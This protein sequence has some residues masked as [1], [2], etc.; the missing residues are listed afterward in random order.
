VPPLLSWRVKDERRTDLWALAGLAHLS[1]GEDAGPQHIFPVFYRDE[2]GETFISPVWATWR[3]GGEHWR[4]VPPLLTAYSKDKLFSP[5]VG[6]DKG[7]RGGFVYPVTPLAGFRH[8]DYSGSWLFPLFSHRRH[9]TS[10]NIQ[11]SFLWGNY[12]KDSRTSRSGIFPVYGYRNHGAFELADTD[13]TLYGTYGKE[14][15][16]LPLIWYRNLLHV[17]PERSRQKNEDPPPQVRRYS[18]KHGAFPL[19]SYA[20]STRPA[21]GNERVDGSL[22]LK[23]YDYRRRVTPPPGADED[24]REYVRRRVLWRLW[25]YERTNNDVS[26]DIFPAVTYDRKGDSFKKV[27]LLWRFFRYERDEDKRELDLLFIP[28]R[29]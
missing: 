4:C 7:K 9:K 25:H 1:S 23:L 28:V 21:R 24:P 5:L 10:G 20:K 16:G 12:R 19:W 13:K 8:G 2:D 27:S 6:W 14:F 3:D 26:V 17:Y 22:L 18:R 15:T 29:R 11:G